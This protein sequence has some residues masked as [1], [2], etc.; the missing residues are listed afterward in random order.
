MR[1]VFAAAEAPGHMEFSGVEAT[2]WVADLLA[3]STAKRHS[4]NDLCPQAFRELA[5][6]Q[7]RG[8]SWL[9]FLRRWGLGLPGG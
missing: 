2:G 1:L 7:V 5:P 6:L 9:S 3:N 4:Q 8:Y